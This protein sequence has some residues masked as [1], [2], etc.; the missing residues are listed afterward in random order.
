M[1]LGIINDKTKSVQAQWDERIG[2]IED[3]IN[4]N[5]TVYDMG[6]QEQKRQKAIHEASK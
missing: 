6:V 2:N 4:G 3:V 5:I 1:P